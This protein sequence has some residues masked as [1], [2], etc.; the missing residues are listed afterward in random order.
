MGPRFAST[1][2]L[3]QRYNNFRELGPNPVGGWLAGRCDCL[4]AAEYSRVTDP[5]SLL[6]AEA[7]K[8]T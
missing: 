8:L 4:R 1:T 6:A 7:A 5:R 2:T 3:Q